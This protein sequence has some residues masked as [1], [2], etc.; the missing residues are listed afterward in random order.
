[1]DYNLRSTAINEKWTIL[2]SSSV[3]K[4]KGH[5]QSAQ[6]EVLGKQ[7]GN[8]FTDRTNKNDED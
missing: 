1:M 3:Q 5:N 7:R 4:I 2:H 8:L 6:P